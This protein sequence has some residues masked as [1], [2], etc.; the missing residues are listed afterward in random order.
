VWSGVLCPVLF[1]LAFFIAG[2]VP[3]LPAGDSAQEIA[4]HYQDNTTS[5]RVAGVA[6]LLSSMFYASFTAVISAQM[7]RIPGVHRTVI[8][9][10]A[11]AGAFACLTF[12]VPA[13]LFEV[14]AFRPDRPAETTQMLNDFAWI[15][16]VMPWPPFLVQNWAFAFAILTDARE[17]TLFPRWLA[18]LNFWAP[19]IFSPSVLL[20]FFKTGPFAWQGIF[21]IWIPAIV[22]VIQFFANV[23]W[24]R[25]AVADEEALEGPGLALTGRR[26][27]RDQPFQPE[28]IAMRPGA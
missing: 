11:V 10:Q 6:M 8:Y 27:D 4:S 23:F 13:M 5:V 9:T 28:A 18:Y 22:F 25:R 1:F 12:L 7:Q 20:P 2:F 24:L 16:L 14:V 15:F 26:A 21:V 19:L 17:R 3:P